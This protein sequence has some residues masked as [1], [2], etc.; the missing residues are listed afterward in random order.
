MP[1]RRF[2]LNSARSGS[3]VNVIVT[4]TVAPSV[5]ATSTTR[6]RLAENVL[7]LLVAPDLLLVFRWWHALDRLP[8]PMPRLLQ[9]HE[10]PSLRTLVFPAVDAGRQR[11]WL[12]RLK[13]QSYKRGR[14]MLEKAVNVAILVVATFFVVQQVRGGPRPPGPS[15]VPNYKVGDRIAKPQDLSLSKSPLTL[16]LATQS[17][18]K[19][20]TASLPFYARLADRAQSAGVRFIG[21]TNEGIEVNAKYLQNGNVPITEIVDVAQTELKI[22]GTPTLLL[23]RSDGEVVRAWHGRLK[24][25]EEEEVLQALQQMG[26]PSPR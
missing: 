6:C 24:P 15:Q 11:P 8:T 7:R 1:A 9:I 12:A 17:T 26:A 20:C 14:A 2:F 5:R 23:L 3:F 19:Y 22:R 21:V 10:L 18:C 13:G 25:S 4:R 16:V